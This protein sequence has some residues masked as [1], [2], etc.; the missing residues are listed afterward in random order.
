MKHKALVQVALAMAALAVGGLLYVLDR[1][2]GSTHFLTE[3]SAH[4]ESGARHFGPLGANLPS[5][6][7]I[8]A[9]ILLTVAIL[10]PGTRGLLIVCGAW[11]CIDALFEVQQ[12]LAHC[13]ARSLSETYL[14]TAAGGIFD[15]LDIAALALGAAAAFATAILTR[16]RVKL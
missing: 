13:C 9:F 12:Y 1:P 14:L 2:A 16:G 6:L 3:A 4:S 10:R 8:Y 15:P 5:F 11:F 7:H